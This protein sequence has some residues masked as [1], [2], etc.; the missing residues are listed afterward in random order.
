[1]LHVL[2]PVTGVR[3]D[4]SDV[5]DPVFAQGLV[6]PGMA[7]SPVA[8]VQSAVAPIEGRLL[9]VH[10]HAFL[11][12]SDHGPGVLVHLGIDTVQL[13]GEG[14]TALAAQNTAVAAGQEVVRWDPGLVSRSGRSPICAVVV[15]DCPVD[16]VPLT[17]SGSAVE[18]GGPLFSIEC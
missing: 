16:A 8:G 5:P 18:A 2:S 4:V 10:P 11:V 14:F 1:M 7:I 13:D 17:Q 6:G 12:V 15:V 3:H 9:K